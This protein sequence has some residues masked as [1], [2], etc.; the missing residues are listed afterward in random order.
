[1]IGAQSEDN[2][3]D[4]ADLYRIGTGCRIVGSVPLDASDRSVSVDLQRILPNTV[5]RSY[6]R[7]GS[8]WVTPSGITPQIRPS[9]TVADGGRSC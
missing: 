1:M 6:R 5:G 4:K 3:E 2:T 7:T 8:F 9:A